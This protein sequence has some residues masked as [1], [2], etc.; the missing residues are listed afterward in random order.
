MIHVPESGFLAV[1][2]E[3]DNNG[4]GEANVIMHDTLDRPEIT[5]NVRSVARDPPSGVGC[6][7]DMGAHG[8]LAHL[9]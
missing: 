2:L 7:N 6:H 3:L 4:G 9:R 1:P 8:H 5:V